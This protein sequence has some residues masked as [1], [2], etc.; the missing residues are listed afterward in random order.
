M[1]QLRYLSGH[2]EYNT[3]PTSKLKS[4]LA[5]NPTICL[6]SNTGI[7]IYHI[8]ENHP[9]QPN[10]LILHQSSNTSNNNKKW[11]MKEEPGTSDPPV[12]RFKTSTYKRNLYKQWY[13]SN[14]IWITRRQRSQRR[15][16]RIIHLLNQNP[17]IDI[18]QLLQL[19]KTTTPS[20][21]NILPTTNKL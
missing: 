11:E 6:L 10:Q 12:K 14:R 7:S 17:N 3:F 20:L 8:F 2:T 18:E 5:K 21:S 13:K 19:Q 15:K 9:T 16:K 1:I 4:F